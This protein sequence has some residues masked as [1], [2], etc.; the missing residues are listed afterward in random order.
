MNVDSFQKETI[1]RYQSYWQ[2]RQFIEGEYDID[3]DFDK[4]EFEAQQ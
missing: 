2:G 1:E 3:D 4:I